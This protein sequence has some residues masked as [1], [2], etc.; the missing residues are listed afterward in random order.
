MGA[1]N[2]SLLVACAARQSQDAGRIHDFLMEHKPHVIAVG[3]ANLHCRQ[4]LSDLKS[5]RDNF[6]SEHPRFIIS[7]AGNMEVVFAPET[8]AQLW[9]NSESARAELGEHT[10]IVRRAVALGRTL[11]DPLAVLSCLRG[12]HR[13]RI[14]ET[15]KLTKLSSAKFERNLIGWKGLHLFHRV[16]VLAPHCCLCQTDPMGQCVDL[17]MFVSRFPDHGDSILSLPLYDMQK[18]L[19][20]QELLGAIDQVIIT[21]V[22]QLGVNLNVVAN[23]PWRAAAL[24][25]ISGLGPR[26]SQAILSAIQKN[27][28]KVE[29]RWELINEFDILGKRV[30]K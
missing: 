19:S 13:D 28:N 25:F 17:V 23:I 8:L 26:K 30:A 2:N 6:L 24:Q 12:D 29:S 10:A 7:I 18:A 5:I 11:L 27:G 21:A 22:N 20:R 1:L 4:L 14:G 9:E 3:G 15:F 16:K